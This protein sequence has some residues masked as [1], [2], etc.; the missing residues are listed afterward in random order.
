MCLLESFSKIELAKSSIRL[1]K[2]TSTP[3][4]SGCIQM[5]YLSLISF[6][7]IPNKNTF[8]LSF[9]EAL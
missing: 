3:Q 6:L 1:K 4:S 2:V 9:G 5:G 7:R 8:G